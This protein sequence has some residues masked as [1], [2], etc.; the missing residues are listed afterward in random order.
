M[1]KK[2]KK[3]LVVDDETDFLEM[4][5]LRLEA[6][7][8]EVMT[9]TNGKEALRKVKAE[10]PDAV[11]LDILIPAPDGINV[12]KTIRKTDKNLPVFIITAFSNEERFKLANQL[13]ASGFIVK[14]NDLKKEIDNITN[15]I[16]LSDKF[17]SG[18]YF[19]NI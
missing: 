16:K 1:E 4:I 12:L 7:D 3:I 19:T 5:K 18:A 6:N 8:Y 2:K 13:A 11:L 15:A 10:K 9:A 17:K 14:T